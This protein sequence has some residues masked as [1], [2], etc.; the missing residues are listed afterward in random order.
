MRFEKSRP[1]RTVSTRYSGEGGTPDVSA[2][3]NINKSNS[4]PLSAYKW[5]FESTSVGRE[6]FSFHSLLA[7][8]STISLIIRDSSVANVIKSCYDY[9]AIYILQVYQLYY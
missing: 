7:A 9:F 4:M 5:P 2:S 8:S 3:N 1:N 6:T